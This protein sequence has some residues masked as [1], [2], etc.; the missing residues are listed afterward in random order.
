MQ[1]SQFWVTTEL[2][3]CLKSKQQNLKFELQLHTWNNA[4]EQLFINQYWA[5][6][7]PYKIKDKNYRS[8]N[9]F[10][11]SLRQEEKGLNLTLFSGTSSLCASLNLTGEKQIIYSMYNT[12]DGSA[13][14][15]GMKMKYL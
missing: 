4:Y 10:A 15:H 8:N 6:L 13:V 14:E 2:F 1:E 11:D 7:S 5:Y 3:L 12:T 9:L